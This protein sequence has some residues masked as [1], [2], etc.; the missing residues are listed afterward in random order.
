MISMPHYCSDGTS[1]QDYAHEKAWGHPVQ[2]TVL[3]LSSG[4]RYMPLNT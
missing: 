3:R 1:F 2:D 4:S